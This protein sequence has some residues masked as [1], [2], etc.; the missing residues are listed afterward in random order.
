LW[1]QKTIHQLE[2]QEFDALD[3][4]H[5]IEELKDLGKSDKTSFVSNLKILLAHLLKLHVQAD[6]PDTMRQSWLNSI[7]D[8]A[9]LRVCVY[10]RDD[11][12]VF[13]L[14]MYGDFSRKRNDEH[15]DAAAFCIQKL[16]RVESWFFISTF[17][18]F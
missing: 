10:A 16:C 1:I 3:I 13:P 4:P 18:F 9:R 15:E 11:E 14:V 17:Y 12:R 2:S 6:A 8:V 5:L 7:L